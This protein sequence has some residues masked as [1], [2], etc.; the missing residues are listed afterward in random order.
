MYSLRQ[1]STDSVAILQRNKRWTEQLHLLHFPCWPQ[2]I[3][4]SIK[5]HPDWYVMV[6]K[7]TQIVVILPPLMI[8]AVILTR[9]IDIR[10][11]AAFWKGTCAPLNGTSGICRWCGLA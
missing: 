8:G 4:H 7:K 10:H 2:G 11:Q 6:K 3:Y 1:S 9:M 5:Y